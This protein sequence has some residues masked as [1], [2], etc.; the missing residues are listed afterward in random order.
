[1]KGSHTC[2]CNTFTPQIKGT[3]EDTCSWVM[4][5]S[6]L[7]YNSMSTGIH[8]DVAW[9]NC[10]HQTSTT[11]W[12]KLIRSLLFGYSG[13]L[14]L[15]IVETYTLELWDLVL[16]NLPWKA[17]GILLWDSIIMLKLTQWININ[18]AQWQLLFSLQPTIKL[19][20]K[21][22]SVSGLCC[23]QF[24]RVM[25]CISCTIQLYPPQALSIHIRQIARSL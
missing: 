5:T 14:A 25:L 11:L 16:C 15:D 22:R 2:I 4:Y 12:S 24:T 1:M 21:Y 9:K 13:F 18:I 19:P 17:C 3:H 8:F 10:T 20:Y 23:F 6:F 7:G